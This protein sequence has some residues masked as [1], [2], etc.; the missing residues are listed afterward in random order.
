MLMNYDFKQFFKGYSNSL[1]SSSKLLVSELTVATVCILNVTGC[2]PPGAA[3]RLA[4]AGPT[5]SN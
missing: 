1:L 3:V 4:G 5:R 2:P